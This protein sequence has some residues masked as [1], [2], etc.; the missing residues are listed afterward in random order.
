MSEQEHWDSRYKQPNQAPWDT[1]RPSA[2]LQRQLAK[3]KLKPS[4]AVELGCGTG[5]NAIW[6]AQQ[7]FDVTAIDL[8]PTAIERAGAKAAEADVRVRFLQA[9]VMALPDLG[10]LFPFFFDRGCYHVVRR[11]N[12]DGFLSSLSK[13]TAAAAEG[14]VLTGN[15]KEPHSPGPPVV[16]EAE[17]R[18]ELGR[19][20]E[21]VSLEEFRF[22]QDPVTNMRFLG[23]S[24]WLRKRK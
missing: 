17:I 3:R 2:E 15:A 8:S 4:R 24:C 19:D 9:D 18:A 6:L 13:I 1:G 14:L 12:V 10:P 11:E 21:I 7:G 20:F 16:S 5:T 22:D 23:W